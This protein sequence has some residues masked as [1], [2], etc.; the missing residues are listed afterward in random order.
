MSTIA[1][2][3]QRMKFRRRA[4]G[5][6][7]TVALVA[8]LL[9]FVAAAYTSQVDGALGVTGSGYGGPVVMALIAVLVLIGVIKYEKK[10]STGAST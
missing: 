2:L 8:V 10:G 3:A 7:G 6:V 5:K 4:M 1:S 9:V